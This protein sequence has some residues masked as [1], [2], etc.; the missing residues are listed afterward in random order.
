ML[1]LA[2]EVERHDVLAKL[3]ESIVLMQ[4][5]QNIVDIFS[6]KACDDYDYAKFRKEINSNFERM[7]STLRAVDDR[8]KAEEKKQ[9]EEE[10]KKK[11]EEED[12]KKKEAE[13]KR[14]LRRRKRKR[15][16][17]RRKPRKR[18]G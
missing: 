11:K 8:K 13:E 12:K 7:N 1:E 15:T 16:R 18:G 17:R 3:K 9:K 14:R 10:A 5:M 4:E 6:I 2:K